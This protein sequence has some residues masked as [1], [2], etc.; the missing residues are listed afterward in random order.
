MKLPA[1]SPPVPF[2]SRDPLLAIA[3]FAQAW[4][5]AP[6]D[7]HTSKTLLEAIRAWERMPRFV[8]GEP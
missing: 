1:R 5:D 6:D 2:V 3:Q 8:W 4:R 7:A